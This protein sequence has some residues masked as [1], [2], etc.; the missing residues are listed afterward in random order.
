MLESKYLHRLVLVFLACVFLTTCIMLFWTRQHYRMYE[1]ALID[2]HASLTGA[3]LSGH[4]ELEEDIVD[5]ILSDEDHKE[6]GMKILEKY[7][8]GDTEVYYRIR[9]LRALEEKMEIDTIWMVLISFGIVSFVFFFYIVREHKKVKEL[10]RYMNRILNGDYSLDI[11][12]YEEGEMS[13]LKN[14]IYKMTVLLKEKSD[15]AMKDKLALE[16]TLSDISHQIK[17]PLTSMYVMNDLLSDSDMDLNTRQEF[18]SKNRKQL[19]RIE[20]LV[21]S[22]LKL[23]RMESGMIQMKHHRINVKKLVSSSI[24]PLR[25]PIELK[26]QKLV[27]DIKK[28]L[29]I[30]GDEAWLTEALVNILKNAHEHTDEGGTIT[31]CANNNPIYKEI[32]ITDNG[33][34]IDKEDLPHLFERFYKAKTSKSDSVGIGLHLAEKIVKSM[35]G[36]ILVES[37]VLKGTTFRLRF[38]K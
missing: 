11:R 37:E 13:H 1:Q 31:I 12:D 5:S 15:G 32:V 26:N 17:T 4:P 20:W 38:Y 6:S 33:C 34:G 22:L 21:S 3:I 16:E 9:D 8:L 30:I 14:E 7:G 18:L 19:G 27:I 23:S 35:Q 10:N 36:E 28:N 25:I 24:D 29:F 2:A